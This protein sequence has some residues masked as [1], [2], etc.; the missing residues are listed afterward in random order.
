M[1][2]LFNTTFELN[3]MGFYG[4]KSVWGILVLVFGAEDKGIAVGGELG[5][6]G[7]AGS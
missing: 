6:E 1:A 3:K 2:F 7:S 4:S 5:L